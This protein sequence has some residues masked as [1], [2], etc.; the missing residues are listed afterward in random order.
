MTEPR[1]QKNQRRTCVVLAANAIRIARTRRSPKRCDRDAVIAV[2]WMLSALLD[3][4]AN[5]TDR[6]RTD[7][8]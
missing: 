7:A 8:H 5:P 6:R 1:W 2:M 3:A 4:E